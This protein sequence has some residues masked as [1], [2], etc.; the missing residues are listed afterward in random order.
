MTK[1]VKPETQLTEQPENTRRALVKTAAQVAVSAPAMM[2]L[3][4]AGTKPAEAA[5]AY[6]VGFDG[7]SEPGLGRDG[8]GDDVT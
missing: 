6:V 2:V 7:G 4:S 8:L 1:E 3:L 5:T